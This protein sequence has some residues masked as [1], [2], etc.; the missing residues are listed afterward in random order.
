MPGEFRVGSTSAGD[1]FLGALLPGLVLV[2][3][4]MLYV[5]VYARLNPKAAP[6]V[7]F[8]GQFDFKFWMKVIMV[9]IPPLALIFAVLGSILMGIATV[10]QAGSIGA[11]GATIMAG[12]RLHQGK[13]DAD[14]P[15]LISVIS[16]IPIFILSKNFN[17]NIKAV[18]TRDFAAILVTAFFTAT[19]LIGIVWSFWRA[20]KVNDVLKEVVTETCVTT[21]MVFIILLGAAMLTSGFRAFGGEELVRD[22]LQDLPGG[23]WTQFIVVMAVIFLLGFF[24]DF[25]EIAV[26]V[27]PIIA[28]I[29]LAETGANV[30]AIWLG[31]MIGVNLQTSFLTP[32]FGFALFYPVSY[33][34]LTLPT[35]A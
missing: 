32:P 13:K 1:M 20:Y 26:V 35:K 8:K 15:L 27:V 34:H 28:P 22:F 29:L 11:I 25:I 9:I 2:G 14:Y 31:V 6:P 18:E 33:T 5:F 4:Y 16:I 3:L 30:S 12:Y 24:L 21:S 7:P 10:N 19:F 17:L 23:F